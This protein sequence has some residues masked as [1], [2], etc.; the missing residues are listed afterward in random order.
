LRERRRRLT[1]RYVLVA[2]M[3]VI[4]AMLLL[5]GLTYILAEGKSCDVPL[6]SPA[7]QALTGWIS[8][9]PVAIALGASILIVGR[10]DRRP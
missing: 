10:Q 3:V 5:Q 2:L 4:L 8:L 7:R 9:L 1:A 6:R